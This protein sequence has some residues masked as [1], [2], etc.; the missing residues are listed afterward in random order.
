MVLFFFWDSL[1]VIRKYVYDF[2][3]VKIHCSKVVRQITE[4]TS[5]KNQEYF[6]QAAAF[7][8]NTHANQQLIRVGT[9]PVPVKDFDIC[10]WK[11]T[12]ILCCYTAHKRVLT[13]CKIF[14]CIYITQRAGLWTIQTVWVELYKKRPAI[15][16]KVRIL[17]YCIKK[18]PEIELKTFH[19]PNTSWWRFPITQKKYAHN[20]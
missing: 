3:N 18:T 6:R 5:K 20:I 7:Y 2:I 11:I 16:F 10:I 12:K 15:I 14:H 17:E 8:K 19:F 13:P 4:A 1:L 9:P